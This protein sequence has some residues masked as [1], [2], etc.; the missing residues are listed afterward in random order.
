M[1]NVKIVTDGS[2]YGTKVY[3]E[4][5]HEVKGIAKAEI[6][7]LPGSIEAVLTLAG[8]SLDST[9]LSARYVMFHPVHGGM[10]EVEEVTFKDGFVRR[11][12]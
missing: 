12:D 6:T 1:P 4:D 3:T 9:A 8:L 11:F 2:A 10:S 5:G 7:I